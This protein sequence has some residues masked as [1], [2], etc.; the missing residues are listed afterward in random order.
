MK[1]NAM[2]KKMKHTKKSKKNGIDSI[3]SDLTKF[4]S[5]SVM[6]EKSGDMTPY[7]IPFAHKGLQYITGG[8]PGGRFTQIEGDSQCG[9]SYLLYELISE[10]LNMGGYALLNDP[11]IAYEP[12]FGARVGITGDKK[13]I[14]SKNKSLETFFDLSRKFIK[15]VRKSN[16]KCPILIGLDSYPPLLP[17]LTIKEFDT[18]QD[19]KSLKGYIHAKK[20]NILALK[21]GEFVSFL[22]EKQATC[23]MINQ[24]KM[25]MNVMF[26][27]PRTSNA[28]NVIKYYCTLRLRGDFG[29]KIRDKDKNVL[30]VISKWETIKNRNITPFKKVAV[31]INYRKGVEPYSGLYELLINE[32]KVE[33]CKIKKFNA[34]KYKNK[35]FKKSSMK[36][37]IKRYPEILIGGQYGITSENDG[38]SQ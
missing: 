1:G 38:S 28:E 23:V 15:A 10:T 32:N 4:F 36:K 20:N 34:F 22:D 37:V 30:G 16:K 12:E 2:K 8:V 35:K 13:F 19:E 33:K 5:I 24:T 11:E 14:Y 31:D 18:V 3:V 17:N 29:K 26:G 7:Y 27:D 21:L 9:K 6:S 25:K